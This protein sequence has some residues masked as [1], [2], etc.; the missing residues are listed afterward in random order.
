MD[1]KL[2]PVQRADMIVERLAAGQS[3]LSLGIR[4]ARTPDIV[5]MAAT[6]GYDVV[7]IDL[8]HSMMSLETACL[9][10]QTARDIGLAAW[11][12]PP[13]QDYGA[14][15]RLLDG[16]ASGI[17]ATHIATADDARKAVASCRYP[18]R[19]ERS[20][21]ALLPQL[22][23]E[24]MPAAKRVEVVDRQTVLQVLI[25][26]E[27][28]VRNAEAIA[29]V[30]GVDLI[31]LGLNDLSSQ[32]GCIGQPRHPEIMS[33]CRH[34]A[35]AVRRQGKQLVVGGV[36][37]PEHFNELVELGVAPLA[38]AAIDTEILIEALD[39]RAAKWR[40]GQTSLNTHDRTSQ[41]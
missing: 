35:K 9:L 39:G 27:E 33:A 20:Q 31:A 11:V 1:H 29:A 2:R 15:G 10:A 13:E 22:A 19:G 3:L 5:R 21:N 4:T 14:I 30:D 40:A 12:R 38:F 16:G 34:V 41:S 28:G 18:P 25:E 6:C 32:L 7:W 24:R 37:D 23:F 8:E 36:T 26:S 17:I